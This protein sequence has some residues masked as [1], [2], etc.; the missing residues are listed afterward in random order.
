MIF[1]A[2]YSKENDNQGFFADQTP[3]CSRQGRSEP[4]HRV[5]AHWSL[6]TG[7]AAMCEGANRRGGKAPQ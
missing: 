5:P 7:G 6:R 2:G 3:R 4:V 1:L